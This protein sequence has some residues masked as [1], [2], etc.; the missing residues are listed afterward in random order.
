M[1]QLKIKLFSIALCLGLT[2]TVAPVPAKAADTSL[3]LEIV[4][5]NESESVSFSHLE[6]DTLTQ[7]SIETTSPYTEGSQQFTGPLLTTVLRRATNS[8]WSDQTKLTLTALNDYVVT[9]TVD[10][11]RNSQAI[12]ATKKGGVRLSVRERGPFWI[13]IPLSDRPELDN[14]DFHRLMIWQLSKIEIGH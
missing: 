14:E 9:T 3:T 8:D 5:N 11:L 2:L 1:G 12:V 10:K 6:L 13:M 7:H 4:F